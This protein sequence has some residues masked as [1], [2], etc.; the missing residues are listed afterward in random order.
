[1]LTTTATKV[2]PVV[3]PRTLASRPL[4]TASDCP[5][6]KSP[7]TGSRG[8]SLPQAA[9]R[10]TL[11]TKH[12][13][14]DRRMRRRLGEMELRSNAGAGLQGRTMTSTDGVPSVG[15]GAQVPPK[16][17]ACARSSKASA[18]LCVD[19][20]HGAVEC[21]SLATRCSAKASREPSMGSERGRLKR[22]LRWG[23]GAE[24][25]LGALLAGEGRDEQIPLP[26][27]AP[28][29]REE[30][31]LL[32]SLDPFGDHVHPQGLTERDDGRRDRAVVG[33][34]GH[35]TDEA[36]VDLEGVDR[37]ESQRAER[38][39]ARPQIVDRHPHALRLE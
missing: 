36:A 12:R 19:N 2:P 5:R 9:R 28:M 37:K 30:R 18:A 10:S 20:D 27:P 32:R 38:R 21:H 24:Q 11:L 29:R 7:P 3:P 25:Q 8:P 39:V 17:L 26:L 34:V 22:K 14:V 6:E 4:S 23:L 16:P 1:M 35:A 33:V 13:R 15:A 31:E